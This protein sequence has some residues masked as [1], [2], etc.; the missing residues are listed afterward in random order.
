MALRSS[1]ACAGHQNQSARKFDAGDKVDTGLWLNDSA[2]PITESVSKASKPHEP[3]K[4]KNRISADM[5]G[6][7]GLILP[8]HHCPKLRGC[9]AAS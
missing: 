9:K 3:D 4:K 5:K 2:F 8:T 6:N 7:F 1:F